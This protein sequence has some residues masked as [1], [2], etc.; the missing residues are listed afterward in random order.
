MIIT[1]FLIIL[2]TFFVNI[3]W[4]VVLTS[5]LVIIPM[6]FIKDDIR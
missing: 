3:L 1:N 5:L 6:M 2:T 4:T